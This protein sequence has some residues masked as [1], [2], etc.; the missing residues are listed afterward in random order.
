M[1]VDY[2]FFLIENYKL[3]VQFTNKL[4]LFIANDI[5]Y[6]LFISCYRIV[7][8]MGNLTEIIGN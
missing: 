2:I 3:Y 6:K 1:P 7:Q 4:K 8:T 5:N